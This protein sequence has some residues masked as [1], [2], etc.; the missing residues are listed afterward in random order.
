MNSRYTHRLRCMAVP[1]LLA[2]LLITGS[3]VAA[4][5][6]FHGGSFTAHNAGSATI[7][8]GCNLSTSCTVL[9]TGTGTATYLGSVKESGSFTGKITHYPCGTG[10][11]STTMTSATTPSNA[12]T[13]VV[14][15]RA[16]LK[17]GGLQIT[18]A[19]RFT[20]GK[21]VFVKAA[22]TGMLTGTFKF[23]K[24]YTDTWT[25]TLTY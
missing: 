17:N 21:G 6:P 1:A 16:C 22:G 14:T 23:T 9:L 4:D 25:G 19:Y 2:A 3:A 20:S 15:G 18:A 13:A 11:G 8:P 12:V 7:Q 24:T 5:T 10:S